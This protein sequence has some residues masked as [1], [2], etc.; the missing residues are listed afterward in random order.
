MKRL[1][2]PF[3]LLLKMA[4]KAL[5][6]LWKRKVI[7]WGSQ[8]NKQRYKCNNCGQLY[9]WRNELKGKEKQLI[10]F[11]QWV[12]HHQTLEFISKSSG[13]SKRTLQHLFY[14]YLELIPKHKVINREQVH[15]LVDGTYFS[16]DICLVVYRDNDIKQTMLYRITT[17][18]LTNEIIEDFRNLITVGFLIESITCDGHRSILKS[19]K[20][21]FKNSV[22]Q[23][24]Y[25]K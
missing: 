13:Y 7:L 4:K 6:Y 10:C 14:E 18:E 1:I 24:Q 2:I 16:K 5:L 21:D 9:T 23:S 17:D 8:N 3:S 12:L 22:L 20:K 25:T 19:I 15:L 11:K